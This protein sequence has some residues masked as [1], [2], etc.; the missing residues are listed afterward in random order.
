[1]STYHRAWKPRYSDTANEN[2]DDYI[3]VPR[4]MIRSEG[5]YFILRVQGESMINA[6]IN[7]GD[8][9]VVKIHTGRR[10]RARCCRINELR[11]RSNRQTPDRCGKENKAENPAI[12]DIYPQSERGVLF[13]VLSD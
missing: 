1:M 12:P 9:A 2:I 13:S 5:N 11:Q 3:V 8:L 6:G 4:R 10:A 7:D